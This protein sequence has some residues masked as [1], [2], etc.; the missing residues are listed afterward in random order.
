MTESPAPARRRRGRPPAAPEDQ[1]ARQALIRAGLVHLT[2]RGYGA[3]A[4]D[5]I[6]AAAG[7]T[8]G[9]FYHHFASKAEFGAALIE[10]YGADFLAVLHRSLDRAD[11][12]PLDRLGAFA[13]GAEAWMAAH[14]YRRGC[15]VGNLGQ[16]MAALPEDYRARLQA[17]LADWQEATARCLRTAQAAG[18]IG[19]SED[20]E[21]LAALFWTGWEGAVLRAKLDRG[22]EPLR[23]FI[24]AFLRLVS[25]ERKIP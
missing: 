22:P 7:V 16:E 18:E 6:L 13:A 17:V 21:A 15:L 19:P 2:E 11:L 8:K 12:L 1:A 5:E 23:A 20:P 4:L 9:S 14:G 25:L 24:A 10:A 3:T